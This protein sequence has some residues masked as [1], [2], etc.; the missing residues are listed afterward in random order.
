[1]QKIQTLRALVRRDS[2]VGSIYLDRLIEVL[3]LMFKS[4]F[5]LIVNEDKTKKT[6]LGH[7]YMDIKQD[8]TGAIRVKLGRLK[9]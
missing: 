3:G 5:E 8:I 9:A 6:R 1:M 4:D 7:K 2:G